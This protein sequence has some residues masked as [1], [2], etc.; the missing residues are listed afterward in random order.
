MPRK[1]DVHVNPQGDK[2]TVKVEG[3]KQVSSTHPT[4]A[5]AIDAGRAAAKRNQAELLV[6][7]RDGKIRERNTYAPK[8]PHPPKG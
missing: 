5:K 3:N 7:G 1:G 2:W 4:Q 6:H 8:D